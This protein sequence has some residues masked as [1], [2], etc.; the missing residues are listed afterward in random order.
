[1]SNI[2][3][4]LNELNELVA[5]VGKLEPGVVKRITPSLIRLRNNLQ[6]RYKTLD[7]VKV[8][9][10]QLRLDLKYIVFDL[11]ATRR[12]RDKFKALWENRP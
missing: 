9:L 7:Q 4:E 6:K 3:N 2:P 1:M 10:D 8:A 11:E 12:E 5:I